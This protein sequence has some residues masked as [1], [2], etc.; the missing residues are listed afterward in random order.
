MSTLPDA[1]RALRERYGLDPG[2]VEAIAPISPISN[3]SA[4][5]CFCVAVFCG[6]WL[7]FCGLLGS[8][9]QEEFNRHVQRAFA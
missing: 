2:G 6:K 8:A 5:S 1:C 7:S 3:V 9:L 4:V